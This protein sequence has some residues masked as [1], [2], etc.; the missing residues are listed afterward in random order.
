MFFRVFDLKMFRS[1]LDEKLQY[2]NEKYGIT[3]K[4]DQNTILIDGKKL[5]GLEGDILCIDEVDGILIVIDEKKYQN[6]HAFSLAGEWMWDIEPVRDEKGEAFTYFSHVAG[7]E[8]DESGQKQLIVGRDP[9]YF[10]TNLKTG[11]GTKINLIRNDTNE[12]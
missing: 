6:V 9:V 11:R 5:E 8:I 7:I 4:D 12:R 2:A 1:N 3:F 10:Q